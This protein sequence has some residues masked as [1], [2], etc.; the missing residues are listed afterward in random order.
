MA[1]LELERGYDWYEGA[2]SM[3]NV[4]TTYDLCVYWANQVGF[5]VV[6]AVLLLDSGY[7]R[8]MMSALSSGGWGTV[9]VVANTIHTANHILFPYGSLF[10]ANTMLGEV[11]FHVGL[12]ALGAFVLGT[13]VP[14]VYVWVSLALALLSATVGTLA[15]VSPDDWMIFHFE[16]DTAFTYVAWFIFP[17][18]FG[19]SATAARAL[20]A[21]A[22]AI[23]LWYVTHLMYLN[24]GYLRVIYD[25]DYID[26]SLYT[27]I[28]YA[29]YRSSSSKPS[30]KRE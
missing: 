5:L 25:S 22:S 24:Q 6:T 11:A 2:A 18:L 10:T 28:V 17:L 21:T 1:E 19:V 29:L 15:M 27:I 9:Y 16:S 26:Q 4:E 20:A 3:G 14:P 7:R 30:D 8:W 23:A 12:P 13:R